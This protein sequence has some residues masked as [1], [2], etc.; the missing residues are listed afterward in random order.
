MIVY[1]YAANVPIWELLRCEYLKILRIVILCRNNVL[2]RLQLH[3]A[4][5]YGYNRPV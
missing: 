1:M 3:K 4:P 2:T 5:R